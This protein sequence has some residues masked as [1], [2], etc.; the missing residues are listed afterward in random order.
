MYQVNE[1]SLEQLQEITERIIQLQSL[2]ERLRTQCGL[3]G[4]DYQRSVLVCHDGD[5]P[6]A[7]LLS[8]LFALEARMES[9]Q[10]RKQQMC[11]ELV[12]YL[13]ALPG[14]SRRDF[15]IEYYL[16]GNRNFKD[17]ASRIGLSLERTYHLR[18]EVR[19]AFLLL[20]QK[21]IQQQ[22]NDTF[23]TE[24]DNC[25]QCSDTFLTEDDNCQQC[26]DTDDVVG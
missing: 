10:A 23:L 11:L 21:R 7:R 4:I 6:Q 18:R 1:N 22:F 14:Q 20:L 3:K 9:L 26:S 19:E 25:Q 8:Q 17:I 13:L 24:D 15:A 5:G 16:H 2:S 12:D